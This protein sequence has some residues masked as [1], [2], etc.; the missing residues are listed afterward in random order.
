MPRLSSS[1]CEAI[2]Q[3]FLENGPQEWPVF[4]G[5]TIPDSAR[6]AATGG[7]PVTP[8]ELVSFRSEIVAVARKHGFGV[9][10]GRSSLSSFDA[11]A[12]ALLAQH[13]LFSGGEALRDD[14][15]G[16][17]AAVVAPDVVF[18]RFGSAI[19]RYTGGIRNTFQR[20]WMRGRGLDRGNG[21]SQRWAL[22]HELTEDALVQ[23]SERPSIGSDHDLSVAIA[24]AWLRASLVHGKSAMEDI[25]R[26]AILRIRIQNEIRSLADLP[27]NDLTQFLDHA[28]G[29]VN[30]GVAIKQ[31]SNDADRMQSIRI[32]ER[33][34]IQANAQVVDAA[35]AILSAAGQR[36]WLSPKSRTAL[37]HLSSH[38]T[39]FDRS[40]RNALLYLLGRLEGIRLLEGEVSQIRW[41][42]DS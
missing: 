38:R 9:D 36:G 39:V 35:N 21:N 6:Y 19:E 23:I 41:A 3:A 2:V 5:A 10:N 24:E 13:Q 40:E 27:E 34:I 16:F 18:W 14:A 17:V 26:R 20:L 42:M 25:M 12:A 11:E 33:N 28:F 32:D 22:L 30:Q 8:V 1:A 37:E 4:N 31:A 29:V 15:W 7:T